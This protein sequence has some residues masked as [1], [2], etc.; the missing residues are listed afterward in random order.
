[1]WNRNRRETDDGIDQRHSSS[2]RNRHDIEKQMYSFARTDVF[3]IN[4]I[5]FSSNLHDCLRECLYAVSMTC[6]LPIP[7]IYRNDI[8]RKSSFAVLLTHDLFLL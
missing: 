6:N 1:M 3:T 4:G 8:V 7:S 2:P 5:E